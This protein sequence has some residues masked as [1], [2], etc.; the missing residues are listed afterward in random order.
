MFRVCEWSVVCRSGVDNLGWRGW[1]MGGRWMVKY[2]PLNQMMVMG[3]KM[4]F[5]SK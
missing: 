4:G 5:I 1:E 3:D 2:G